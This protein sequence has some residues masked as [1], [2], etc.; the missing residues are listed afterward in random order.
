MLG[1]HRRTRHARGD[2]G[3]EAGD[4]LGERLER[5]VGFGAGQ[6]CAGNLEHQARIGR[7]A[8]LQRGVIQ[9]SQRARKA[10]GPLEQASLLDERGHLL[11]R[12]IEQLGARA[13]DRGRV[14]VADVRDQVAREL[15]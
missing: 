6:A 13:R 9:H 8:H 1:R 4:T 14:Y 3:L 5:Q 7:V 12:P 10:V 2:L 15:L 11:G